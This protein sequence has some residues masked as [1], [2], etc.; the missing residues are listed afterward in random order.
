MSAITALSELFLNSSN[1]QFRCRE[2]VI[3]VYLSKL[4]CK[5]NGRVKIKAMWRNYY[6]ASCFHME[7]FKATEF[8]DAQRWQNDLLDTGHSFDMM[9]IFIQ[10]ACKVRISGI[11][12]DTFVLMNKPEW[13]SYLFK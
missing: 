10:Y 9:Q 1:V 11:E 13:N 2:Q 5:W 7:D 4:A 8:F 3:H 12:M 6:E